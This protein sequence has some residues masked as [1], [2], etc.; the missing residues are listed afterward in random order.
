[1]AAIVCNY[2]SNLDDLK[3]VKLVALSTISSYGM[4]SYDGQTW[5]AKNTFIT[6]VG[7]W[8]GVA[9]NGNI[10][11]CVAS[12]VLSQSSSDFA[13]WQSSTMPISGGYNCIAYGSGKFIAPVPL[14]SSYCYST[15][16]VNWVS[17]N[18]G[19]TGNWR[20]IRFLKDKFF[21]LSSNSSGVLTSYDGTVWSNN[22]LGISGNWND[23]V[24]DN[25]LNTYI[26]IASN[27]EFACHSSDGIVWSSGVN[28]FDSS[29]PISTIVTN[30]SGLFVAVSAGV[31]GK[32]SAYSNNGISWTPSTLPVSGGWSK[33]TY[34]PEY[35]LFSVG[36]STVANISCI[37]YDGKIWYQKPCI[38]AYGLTEMIYTPIS[39]R[40][41]DTL[42]INNNATLTINT[43]QSKFFNTITIANGQLRIVNP[44][45]GFIRFPMGKTVYTA[46][47]NWILANNGLGSIFI[48]G[49]LNVIASGNGLANQVIT[50]PYTDYICALWIETGYNTG[51]YEIWTN[52]TA[53]YGNMIPNEN[54]YNGGLHAAS[55]G[56]VGMF[57][58]Q[59][60]AIPYDKSIILTNCTTLQTSR[61]ITVSS[62]S[63]ILTGANVIGVGIPTTAVV[64]KIVSSTQLEM[65]IACT[66]SSSSV[67]C[68]IFNPYKDQLI[69]KLIFG[70]DIHGKIVPSGARIKI[71]N[72]M[73]TDDTAVNNCRNFGAYNAS[74]VCTNGFPVYIENCLFDESYNNFTQASSCTLKNV[75]MAIA[76]LLVECYN[77]NID[78][79]AN[80][81]IPMRRFYNGMWLNRDYKNYSTG[82]FGWSYLSNAIINNVVM[83]YHNCSFI[84]FGTATPFRL[85]Y[86]SNVTI[87]NI[88]AYQLATVKSKPLFYLISITDSTFTNIESYG[89]SLAYPIS[90]S[91][92]K[93][94]NCIISNSIFNDYH[95]YLLS[96]RN[97]YDPNTGQQFIL[98]KKYYFKARTYF[99]KDTTQYTEGK[100]FSLTPFI[101][102]KTFPDYVS[103]TPTVSQTVA[104]TWTQRLPFYRYEIYRSP[105]SGFATRDYT[106]KVYGNDVTINLTWTNG[107]RTPAIATPSSR[108]VFTSAAKTI[109]TSGTSFLTL[110]YTI[111]D[112]IDVSG[113]GLN[114][115][116]Y[117]ITAVTATLI[118][119]NNSYD[120]IAT[121]SAMSGVLYGRPPIDGTPYFYRFR[122]YDDISTYNESTEF[123]ATTLAPIP[124]Q[125]IILQSQAFDNASWTKSNITVTAGYDRSP[126]T[127]SYLAIATIS[128]DK[129]S[130]SVTN[131]YISQAFTTVSGQPY[132]FS[133]WNRCD[134]V[135]GVELVSGYIGLSGSVTNF[136]KTN[137]VVSGAWQNSSV[138]I[139]ASG[140]ST[141]AFVNINV[142]NQN[143]VLDGAMVTSG[144]IVMP[145]LPTVTLSTTNTNQVRDLILTRVH[146]KDIGDGVT[147]PGFE[148][149]ITAGNPAAI[150]GEHYTAVYCGI[151]S[152]FI[153]SQLNR[154]YDTSVNSYY[155]VIAQTTTDITVDGLS[156]YGKSAIGIYPLTYTDAYS[157]AVY[158]NFTYDYGA[159]NTAG[160]IA[161]N[162]VA[163]GNIK[164]HNWNLSNIRNYPALAYISFTTIN[165]VK[166]I[167]IQNMKCNTTQWPL[168]LNS[169]NTIVKG[170]ACGNAGPLGASLTY[171]L[172]GTTDGIG[173]ANT[174][175]YDTIFYELYFGSTSGCLMLGFNDSTKENPP[176]TLSGTPFFSN[177]GKLYIQNKGD[178]A[179]YT[180]PHKILG[181]SGF[182]GGR[183]PK[184]SGLDLGLN[185]DIL[186]GLKIEYNINKGSG[187]QGFK[188]ANGANLG[189]EVVSPISGFYF[190]VRLTAQQGLKYTSQMQNFVIGERIKGDYS[191]ATAT[192]ERDFAYG[193]TGVLW[194]SDISGSFSTSDMLVRASDDLLHCSGIT[195]TNGDVLFPALTSY[196]DGLQIFTKIDQTVLYPIAQPTLTF[197]DLQPFSEVRV[198]T[199]DKVE[200]GG[201][202]NIGMATTWSMQYDYYDIDISGYVVILNLNYKPLKLEGLVLK[203]ISTSIPVVQI[204][205][206][207]YVNP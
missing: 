19:Y 69:N 12:G 133:I 193:S 91:R 53:E 99:T 2:T 150:S 195:T 160:Q 143:L 184:L 118:T 1:M 52:T 66:A 85:T 7:N 37:T 44:T 190:Q 183:A 98:G 113:T 105:I 138:T 166:D 179:T 46:A 192:V 124:S 128:G 87:S 177:T 147:F 162:I 142:A 78:G 153:P 15:D 24:Y 41:S 181:I 90:C 18:L 186:E 14:R 172:G 130:G 167:T 8:S 194:L 86:S 47:S 187:Y 50:A 16:G 170:M 6:S 58:D 38:G 43:D 114:N 119:V 27:K 36:N 155:G 81:T 197:T 67:T 159:W 134:P 174:A 106:T 103:C 163:G 30:N 20:R 39:W 25:S 189:S 79:F 164:Y 63:G 173:I 123:E 161:N 139:V 144:T 129:I 35:N 122:K 207:Q 42:T 111:G 77:V 29:H 88:R 132:T 185:N 178:G 65:N 149:G 93:F 31:E 109:G 48:S 5:T 131:S 10:C 157:N 136:P 70:D 83:G 23:I 56:R 4:T 100:V 198:F 11:V 61:F 97:M 140:T 180:W 199:N 154:L 64:E 76:P 148:I 57:F 110:G 191:L 45:S 94:K 34:L 89:M 54:C 176:F 33:I 112:V 115:N 146:C 141:T 92:I 40:S 135:I 17:G 32:S 68:T 200:I 80:V 120:T 28:V 175:V 127:P 82:G 151:T 145:H 196:I 96:V 60:I 137:I 168:A 121:E 169:L 117:T 75:G 108:L 22:N 49:S 158:K 21:I 101:A 73:F 152:G 9:T 62:T 202:E 125:N 126:I 13:T 72:I 165:T 182:S 51:T 102:P 26:V 59:G 204:Y 171:S 95:D 203:D 206:R 116:S 74:I 107:P 201:I 104:F 3:P 205:D 84:T 156:Q 188:E 55:S 71:P